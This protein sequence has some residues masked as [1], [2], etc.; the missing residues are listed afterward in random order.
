ML[1]WFQSMMQYMKNIWFLFF[2]AVCWAS[3]IPHHV[4]IKTLQTSHFEILYYAEQQELAN[5][6][7]VQFEKAYS[8]LSQV[9]ET[10]P[11]DRIPVVINDSTDLANGF[12]TRV[13]YPY[14]MLFPVLPDLNDSLGEPVE[15][16]LELITHELAHVISFEP[17]NG[18]MA[19]I[20]SVFGTVIAP[21]LLLPNWWKEGF[22]V[23]A[24]TAIGSGGRLRSIYQ[25]SAIRSYIHE[26]DILIE[27]VAKANEVLPSWPYGS[28]PYFFGSLA[29]S[30]LVQKHGS[31][32]TKELIERHGRRAPYFLSGATDSV[33]QQN[34]EQIY[35]ESLEF[36]KAK[37]QKQF[38]QLS[39][40]PLDQPQ[41][42]QTDDLILRS[43]SL[44]AAG[45]KLAWVSQNK[46]PESRLKIASI[47]E[48]GNILSVEVPVQQKLMREARFFPKSDRILINSIMPASSTEF[49]SD[50]YIYDLS[51]RK[52]QRLT[53]RLRGREARVSPNEESIVFVGLVGGKTHLKTIHI[54]TKK[55]KTLLSSGF[56]ERIA[57]PLYLDDQRILYSV[58]EGGMEKLKIFEVNTSLV[59][60]LPQHGKRMRRPVLKNGTLYFLSDKNGTFNL[61]STTDFLKTPAKTL[62]HVKTMILDFDVINDQNFFS[63]VL[64]NQ[65]SRLFQFQNKESK[66]IPTLDPLVSE[67]SNLIREFPKTELKTE[68]V[69]RPYK[70]WP[71][72]WI[73]FASGSSAENGALLS[74]S[75]TG[76]DPS[77]QHTYQAQLLYDTGIQKLSYN[78]G[79]VNQTA[80]SPWFLQSG[81][82]IRSFAGS[83]A[84]Y[85]NQ[86]HAVA[87]SPDTSA[88]TL[89]WSSQFALLYS[90]YEDDIRSFE[91][92]GPQV[93]LGYS[94]AEQTIWMISPES[95]G[96]AQVS[97]THYLESSNLESHNQL[98]FKTAAYLSGWLP[99][100]HVFSA[101][102]KALATDK[103]IPSTLGDASTFF[104]T[105]L[106]SNFL[107]RGYFEGQFIGR[108]IINTN[109]EYRFPITKSHE[110]WGLLPFYI[111]RI[112]GAFAYDNLALDGFAFRTDLNANESVDRSQIFSS[113]GV[114]IRADTTVGYILPVQLVLGFHQP[115]QKE[116]REEVNFLFQIRSSLGF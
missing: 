38:D 44:N 109:F 95:G 72:Y 20:R 74:V 37:A 107:I 12:A 48:K 71:H 55:I 1:P 79:Y 69:T 89:H 59:T 2:S 6:Y 33:V 111:K 17:A 94:N 31:Q 23:W 57:S 98:R 77:L 45:T 76:Q 103:I 78:L 73:P 99:E 64:T 110:G 24:E 88:L 50:L 61:Y 105:E 108:N 113:A 114:E 21:N 7:A 30:Y 41:Q 56:D 15:W 58:L 81:R 40:I 34:Y 16:S 43:P 39:K 54:P 115:L 13:P 87:F 11:K 42:I 60:P 19:P 80:K 112:H 85:S 5:H 27:N 18:V 96:S 4:K 9:F 53:K 36:W 65:G 35:N 67:Y 91:R 102:L 46:N 51:N 10:M 8:F 47:D 49:Y 63:T 62:S 116:Y 66:K 101:E 93:S 25:E 100:H 22:S 90:R 104:V 3:P 92:I 70:L 84:N 75:T 83:E 32:K 86:V 29:M 14:T 68:N 28:R 52:T 82:F 106:T 97:L 26:N